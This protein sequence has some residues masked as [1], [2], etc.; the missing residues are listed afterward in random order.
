MILC[1]FRARLLLQKLHLNRSPQFLFREIRT[2]SA[3]FHSFN[4]STRSLLY[5][6]P[7]SLLWALAVLGETVMRSHHSR[8]VTNSDAGSHSLPSITPTR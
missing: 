7:G 6:V 8:V 4:R 2:T 5:Q 3:A 1:S